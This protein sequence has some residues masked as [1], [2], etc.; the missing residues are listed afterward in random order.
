[1]NRSRPRTW[2]RRMIASQP[3]IR[4]SRRSCGRSRSS[5]PRPWRRSP[6]SRPSSRRIRS[7]AATLSDV[8]SGAPRPTGH[9]GPPHRPGLPPSVA[10]PT[11]RRRT[12]GHAAGQARGRA[13]APPRARSRQGEGNEIDRLNRRMD[14]MEQKLDRLL[15][16]LDSK[17]GTSNRSEPVRSRAPIRTDLTPSVTTRLDS[18]RE[19]VNTPSTDSLPPPEGASPARPVSPVPF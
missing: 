13:A 6:G 7:R 17:P 16:K 4:R 5:T 12:V 8:R 11:R 10:R 15:E 14:A 9:P 18:V 3:R 2:T 19:A 1:M